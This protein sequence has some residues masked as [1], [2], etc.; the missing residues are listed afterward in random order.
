MK[1]HPVKTDEIGVFIIHRGCLYR[2]PTLDSIFAV[3]D[4]T[5]IAR[6]RSTDDALLFICRSEDENQY[7]NW[8]KQLSTDDVKCKPDNSMHFNRRYDSDQP[9]MTIQEFIQQRRM[10]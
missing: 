9:Q 6:V 1:Q 2:P 4:L 10:Q 3:D 8:C 5:L 7:E